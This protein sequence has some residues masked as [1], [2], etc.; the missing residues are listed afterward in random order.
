MVRI[1]LWY[2]ILFQQHWW[3][4]KCFQSVLK[5]WENNNFHLKERFFSLNYWQVLTT[6]RIALLTCQ[7]NIILGFQVGVQD[8]IRFK[9]ICT[10]TCGVKPSIK[11]L[12]VWGL[13]SDKSGILLYKLLHAINDLSI[14]WMWDDS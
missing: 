14:W 13:L 11:I 4:W 2:R 5:V 3:I 8:Q 12:K 7:L 10:T 1:V 9:W 6:R